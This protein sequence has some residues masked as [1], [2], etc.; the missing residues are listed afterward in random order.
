MVDWSGTFLM[1]KD[2]WRVF[3]TTDHPNGAPF[4]SYPEL[5][6][7]LMDSDFRNS[8]IDKINI[9]AKEIGNIKSIKRTY[10]LYEIVIMTRAAPARILGLK[11]RG[12][13]KPGSVADI[14]IYDPNKSIDDMFRAAEYVFKNGNEIVK[15]GKVLTHMQT[16]TKCLNL[17]YDAK[18]HKKIK[19]WF[20][21]YYSLSLDEFEVDES[22]FT[23]NNFEEIRS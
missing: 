15:K 1:I 11:D 16:V 12:S 10:N 23:E 21:N 4:T 8:E 17:K 14:S 2:P 19:S 7:L 20:N 3:L 9:N 5:I 22:F 6:R 18:I 13:L